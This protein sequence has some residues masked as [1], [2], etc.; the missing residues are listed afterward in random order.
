MHGGR[1]LLLTEKDPVHIDISP[2]N[3]LLIMQAGDSS[4]PD[5]LGK[6]TPEEAKPAPVVPTGQ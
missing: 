4:K 3:A 6:T 1:P 2:A 5:D